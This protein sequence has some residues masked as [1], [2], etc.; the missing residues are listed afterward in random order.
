MNLALV[1][2]IFLVSMIIM[3]ISDLK[4][5]LPIKGLRVKDNLFYEEV[6]IQ[7]LDRKGKKLRNK[8]VASVEVLWKN[9]LVEG[10]TWEAQANMKS[11][12]PH[13]FDN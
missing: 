13:L 7:I 12:Y 8:E 4:S 3:C 9:H 1:Y 6:P 2:P 5:I 10:A 11:H